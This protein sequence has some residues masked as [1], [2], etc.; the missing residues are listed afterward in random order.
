MGQFEVNDELEKHSLTMLFN[1]KTQWC[2]ENEFLFHRSV[3]PTLVKVN[4]YS[5]DI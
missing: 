2:I 3:F 1:V 5:L 4:Y